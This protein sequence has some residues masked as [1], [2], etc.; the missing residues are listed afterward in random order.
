MLA[1]AR[2]LPADQVFID[3]ED[4]VAPGEKN[5]RTREQV[6]QALLQNE[7][8]ATTLVV[9][10]NGVHTRWCYQ[11]VAYIVERA[12][13]RLDCIMLPKVEDASHIYFL[14]HLLTQLEGAGGIDRRDRD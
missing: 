3:L 6:V 4:A 1:K 12:G 5:D 9:R 14:D 13:P 11:D 8:H 2:G 7:R 10:V